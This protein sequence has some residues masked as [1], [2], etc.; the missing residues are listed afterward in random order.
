M[1]EKCDGEFKHTVNSNTHTYSGFRDGVKRRE[2]MERLIITVN[3]SLQVISFTS[4]MGKLT[5]VT[6]DLYVYIF[7]MCLY[8]ETTNQPD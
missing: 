7:K 8:D 4:V 6:L 5:L 2:A 3:A 1:K